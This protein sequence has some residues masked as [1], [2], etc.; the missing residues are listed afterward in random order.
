MTNR[1]QQPK[2]GNKGWIGVDFDGTLAMH[3]FNYDNP[4]VL[5]EP[6][7][8]MLARVK[9][10]LEAGREVR[11]VTARVCG[12][13]PTHIRQGHILALHDW[14]MKHLGRKLHI[15]CE[16]DFHMTE[17]WDDRAVG[18]HKNTGEIRG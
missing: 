4:R 1:V 11:I 9:E 15:T 3:R 8:V 16:K 18:V 5:G 14:C 2:K 10:W 7:P 17:L 6:V 13:Q 12:L